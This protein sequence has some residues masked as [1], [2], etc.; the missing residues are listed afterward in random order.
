VRIKSAAALVG[1]AFSQS[2]SVGAGPV[3]Q[4]G[5]LL[6]TQALAAE[7]ADADVTAL[8]AVF[9]PERVLLTDRPRAEV[10]A[11]LTATVAQR[12]QAERGRP[13]TVAEPSSWVMLLAVFA[14]IGYVIGRRGSDRI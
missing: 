7:R 14:L 8:A 6:A 11:V 10:P 1:L 9:I 3:E 2:T 12:P 4:H 13:E 5:A